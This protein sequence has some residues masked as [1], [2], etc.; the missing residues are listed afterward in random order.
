MKN[1]HFTTYCYGW[2]LQVKVLK[3]PL[4]RKG[5]VKIENLNSIARRIRKNV[6]ERK[7]KTIA[8]KLVKLHVTVA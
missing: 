8:R 4:T 7:S 6:P 5:S 3:Y 1:I 2:P